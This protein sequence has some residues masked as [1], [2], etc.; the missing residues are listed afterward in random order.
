MD[1][2]IKKNIKIGQNKNRARKRP[3]LVKLNLTADI[4]RWCFVDFLCPVT[5]FNNSNCR[6]WTIAVDKHAI[7]FSNVNSDMATWAISP[8][9][10]VSG[11]KASVGIVWAD[12][13]WFI[14]ELSCCLVGDIQN[15]T[16]QLRASLRHDYIKIALC[17]GDNGRAWRIHFVKMNYFCI[18]F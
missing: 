1:I 13:F 4:S 12:R 11:A 10:N 9:N 18:I 3:M 7:L 16:D 8:T 2:R 6:T 15:F 14:C 5:S 17:L